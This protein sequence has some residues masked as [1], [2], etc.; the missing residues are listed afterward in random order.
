LTHR[1]EVILIIS[2]RGDNRGETEHHRETRGHTRGETGSHS[3]RNLHRRDRGRLGEPQ[4]PQ[5]GGDPPPTGD[6]AKVKHK[7]PQ[8]TYESREPQCL[9]TRPNWDPRPPPPSN[10]KQV[11]TPTPEPKQGDTRLRARGWGGPNSDDWRK[12]LALCD[13]DHR[14]WRETKGQHLIICAKDFAN[15]TKNLRGFPLYGAS[16]PVMSGTW[17]AE[18][19]TVARRSAH[20][21]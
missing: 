10:R 5:Q 6:T 11:C 12:G 7:V 20:Q 15:I 13:I 16:Q 18:Q 19:H 17:T 4:G 9:S 8:S 14:I 21:Q 3:K 1:P 2:F